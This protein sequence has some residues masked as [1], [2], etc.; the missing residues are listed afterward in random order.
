MPRGV[1]NDNSPRSTKPRQTEEEK[2]LASFFKAKDDVAASETKL[3]SAKARVEEVEA[4]LVQKNKVLVW[5]TNHPALPDD[6]DPTTATP[7]VAGTEGSEETDEGDVAV[8]TQVD[9]PEATSGTSADDSDDDP[10]AG[11]S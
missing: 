4:E 3:A 5:T 9:A 11:M 2:A 6:F 10:F 7:A 8:V 1:K